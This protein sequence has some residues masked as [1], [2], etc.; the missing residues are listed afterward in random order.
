MMLCTLAIIA[1]L[2][3]PVTVP[4]KDLGGFI[5]VQATLNG[6]GPYT[7]A[8]DTGAAGIAVTPQFAAEVG[9]KPSGAAHAAG[10]GGTVAQVQSATADSIAIGAA[11]VS[12]PTLYIIPLPPDLT[13]QG[14]HG[15]IVGVIGLDLLVRYVVR[16]DYINDTLTFTPPASFTPPAGAA[17]LPI[18]FAMG[19]L[20]QIDGFVDDIPAKFHLDSGN[21]ATTL[22]FDAFVKA[23]DLRSRYPRGIEAQ[24]VG[25]GGA[26]P[27]FLTRL[28]SLRI[29]D[30]TIH[31]LPVLFTAPVGPVLSSTDT[32]GNIG[33]TTLRRFTVTLDYSRSALFLERNSAF[34]APEPVNNSGLGL[35]RL[36]G[37]DFTVNTVAPGSPA[38][39]AGIALGD[40]V[41]AL[42]GEPASELSLGDLKAK[43]D[44]AP[45]ARVTLTV[46]TKTGQRDVVLVL[47]DMLPM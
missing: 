28:H 38:A 22:L 33:Y 5:V 26:V 24:A 17:K 36:A 44:R 6:K 45:G 21:V 15:N 16:I 27:V 29:G 1:A 25:A 8:F 2:T 46:R 23:H 18:H 14:K 39:A 7:F 10:A 43:L 9:L 32:S 30:S 37:G 20:A 13:D 3:T 12:K 4:F 11:D 47:R 40:T 34:A 35:R 42:D 31:D 41:I 19:G